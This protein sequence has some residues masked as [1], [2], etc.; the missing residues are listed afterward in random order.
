MGQVKRSPSVSS[1][2][3]ALRGSC[4]GGSETWGVQQCL[5]KH[6][7]PHPYAH[8]Y[9]HPHPHPAHAQ[10]AHRSSTAINLNHPIPITLARILTS[11][12]AS[13]SGMRGSELL[14]ETD[15]SRGRDPLTPDRR[16]GTG[17]ALGD[18]GAPIP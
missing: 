4:G 1:G 10:E 17:A 18:A 13:S 5:C 14:R 9:A 7:H 12:A 15:S 16:D 3:L 6:A 8:P 2:M 11:P